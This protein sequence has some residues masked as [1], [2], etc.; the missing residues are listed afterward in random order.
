M[1]EAGLPF[2]HV[3]IALLVVSIWGANFAAVKIALIE[4]P[5]LLLC[6]LR[7]VLVAVPLVFFVPRPAVTNRQLLLYGLTMFALQFGFLFLG[8]KLGMSAGLASLVLQF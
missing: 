3:L 6:T 2:R 1:P 5:P 4:L 8:L 7:F